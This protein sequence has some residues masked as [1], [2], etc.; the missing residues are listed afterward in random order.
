MWAYYSLTLD[1]S[2]EYKFGKFFFFFL[3]LYF[4]DYLGGET[5]VQFVFRG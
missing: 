4:S 2:S 5:R 1:I 3:N